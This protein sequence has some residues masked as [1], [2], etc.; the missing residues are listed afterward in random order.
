MNFFEQIGRFFLML[1][2]AF[3][4]PEKGSVLWGSFITEIYKIGISSMSLV[5][6]LSI[7][8][9]A[10]IIIQTDANIDS[11]WIPAYTIGFT[12]RQS[13]I[14][15]FSSTMLCLI[16]AGKVGSNIA[17]EI[18]TMRL[19]EQID[20]L[21][22]MGINSVNYLVLP[23]ILASVFI[24]PFLV[25]LSMALGIAG[26]G[27]FAVQAEIVNFQELTYGL[28]YWFDPFSITYS[29]VK[30]VFFAF[31]IA[32]IPSFYGY[33]VKPSG[34]ALEVGRAGTKSVVI[35]SVMVL[36]INLLVTYFLLL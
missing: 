5:A 25:I 35:S 12:A 19:T 22:V 34:G 18:G 14:L 28:Q 13:I 17:S 30:T 26:G 21:E 20:A 31:F 33:Y 29:L 2:L 24:F 10:V 32:A 16:L 1:K 27:F 11:P 7:F 36:V 9:G 4:K 6:I 23:K 15:E 3:T 8:M